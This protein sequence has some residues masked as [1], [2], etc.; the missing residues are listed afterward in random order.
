MGQIVAKGFN[1]RRFLI[2]GGAAAIAVGLSP[3]MIPAFAS[4][5]VAALTA[6][7][8]KIILD[9]FTPAGVDSRLAEKFAKRQE[10]AALRSQS[11]KFQ[12]TPA[13]LS[14]GKKTLTVAARTVEGNAVSVRQSASLA[15]MGR[16]VSRLKKTDFRLTSAD[17]SAGKGWKDL[18]IVKDSRS[19]VNAPLISDLGKSSFRL[20]KGPKKKPSRFSTDIAV[21]KERKMAPSVQGNAAPDDYQL[22]VGGSFSISRKIDVTA[23]VRYK[24][25]RD[26]ITPSADNQ[27]DSEAVY[28]GTKI[29]F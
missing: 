25:E 10:A 24:S 16:G 17:M 27:R 20:D 22:D 6:S 26:Q 29:R 15:S 28:V 7:S 4:G 5:N 13:G 1:N 19:A 9:K 3:V 2:A 23:G 11:G 14:A 21:A 12:F 18:G 8:S